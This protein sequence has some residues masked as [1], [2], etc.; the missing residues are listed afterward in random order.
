MLLGKLVQTQ[1]IN[2]FYFRAPGE[3]LQEGGRE[4]IH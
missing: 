2:N 4:A 1:L 3:D